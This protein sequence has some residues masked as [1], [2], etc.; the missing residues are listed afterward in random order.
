MISLVPFS[1]LRR[2]EETEAEEKGPAKQRTDKKLQASRNMV[3]CPLGGLWSEA[4]DRT[5]SSFLSEF[6]LCVPMLS[7]C[8]LLL[9]PGQLW[10]PHPN[11]LKPSCQH[12]FIMNTWYLLCDFT[13]WEPMKH[14]EHSLETLH[15]Q[16]TWSRYDGRYCNCWGCSCGLFFLLWYC[17]VPHIAATLSIPV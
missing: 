1:S 8:H 16:K 9:Q 5:F 15:T 3:D 10:W 11:K 4:L 2:P 6:Q 12:I 13:S 14:L 7:S 17:A